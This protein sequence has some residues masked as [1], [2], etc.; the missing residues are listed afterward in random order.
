MKLLAASMP[1]RTQ[2][3]AVVLCIGAAFAL[4]AAVTWQRWGDLIVDTGRELDT[5]K[6]LASGKMLY[7]DVRYYYGPLVPYFHAVLYRA[8]GVEL[9]VLTTAGL[10]LAASLAWLS[11]RLL[12]QFLGR[13]PA[14]VGSVV[15]L[16]INA[17]GYYLHP[18][19]FNFILPYSFPA[20]YGILLGLASVYFL[21]RHRR[22]G[23]S[24]DFAISCAMLSLGALCK[25]ETLVAT[26]AAHAA[27]VIIN[28]RR[29]LLRA[30]MYAFGYVAAALVPV[31]VLGYFRI[32]A[33]TG[34]WRDN[35][36]LPGNLSAS[37]FVLKHSGL[38]DPLGA[39]RSLAQSLGALALMAV[40]A[41]VGAWVE[42]R[43]GNRV[44]ESVGANRDEGVNRPLGL[45]VAILLAVSAGGAVAWNVEPYDA[46]RVLPVLLM[47]GITVCLFR[48]RRAA[49]PSA[50]L[51]AMILLFIFSL[52]SVLRMGLICWAGHYG[53][54]LT[55][56]AI[57][58]LTVIACGVAPSA[59][60]RVGQVRE[61]SWLAVGLSLML[62]IMVL[63]VRERHRNDG[64]FYPKPELQRIQA[65]CGTML[66]AAHF[67]GS[68]DRAVNFLNDAPPQSRVVIFPE[69]AAITFL[70][71]CQNGLGI[72]M[73]FPPD[74]C[75]SYD[76][77]GVIRRLENTPPDY[78]LYD[79]RSVKEYGKTEFG[80]D[81]AT[82]IA[83]WVRKRFKIIATWETQYFGAQVLQRT[84]GLGE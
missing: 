19:V 7:R 10:T 69:G 55:V 3:V 32:R 2:R 54:Y 47:A 76:E 25:L 8:F 42:R 31:V 34:L 15:V 57:L 61:Y 58:S 52:A 12:R 1:V 68:A 37:A 29:P 60:G 46:L 20:T 74:I 38:S 64:I 59:F 78:V 73:F 40:A 51:E 81:Y 72:H 36:L 35:L 11:Y 22:T 26:L 39:F 70:A 56:P 14:T 24:V 75:G 82:E 9:S 80:T 67:V 50:R 48:W 13:L 83:A 84:G 18:N 16:T 21:I 4:N 27:F 28:V 44:T 30:R 49:A 63:H 77:E 5:P 66:C 53:F 79:T 17:F 6:Q 45:A 41:L 43:V 65:R 33:G 71:G 23:R 62:A